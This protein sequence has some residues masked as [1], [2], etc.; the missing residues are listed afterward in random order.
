LI[1]GGSLENAVL[2]R[3]ETI[4]ATEPLRFRDE[5]VRHKILDILGDIVLAGATVGGAYHHHSAGTFLQ[6]GVDEGVGQLMEKELPAPVAFTPPIPAESPA[7]PAMDIMR[8]L[9]VLPHRY[10]FLLVDGF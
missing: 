4:L 5:F 3:N 6:R 9:N 10:P 1:K 2:I 8:L 7:E